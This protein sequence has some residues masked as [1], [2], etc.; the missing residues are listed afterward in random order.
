M[1]PASLTP[2][3]SLPLNINGK[4]DRNALPDPNSGRAELAANF[5]APRT[6]LEQELAGLWSEVLGVGEVGVRD[7]FFDLGGHSLLAVRLFAQIEARLGKKLPL[8]SLFQRPTVEDLAPLL[9]E[10]RP[11]SQRG[12]CSS[13]F[14]RKAPERPFS[15]CT[16]WEETGEER[17]SITASWP[18]SWGPDQPSFGIRSP[19]EPYTRIDQ[20]AAH[21]VDELLRI[22]PH[23]P[24]SW[25]ASVSAAS[26]LSKWPASSTPAGKKWGCWFCSKAPLPP[27]RIKLKWRRGAAVSLARNLQSWAVDMKQEGPEMIWRRLQRKAKVV[28]SRLQRM[29]RRP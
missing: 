19:Q 14:S 7:N 18:G 21:Y 26:S 27:G 22:R 9:E 17:S 23:G 5:L 24:S 28:Q 12:H 29:L 3:P 11:A 16:H 6:P 8:A 20:M 2:L 13:T 25:A 10:D 1:V 15:G 4:V